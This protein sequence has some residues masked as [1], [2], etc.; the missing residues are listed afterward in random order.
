MGVQLLFEGTAT[1]LRIET[2]PI[3]FQH[4]Q[5][6]SFSFLLSKT[7]RQYSLNLILVAKSIFALGMNVCTFKTSIIFDFATSIQIGQES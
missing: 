1:H 2:P 7:S 6:A 4:V 3:E 5:L